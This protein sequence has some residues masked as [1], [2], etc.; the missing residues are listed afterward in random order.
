LPKSRAK[1]ALNVSIRAIFDKD[2]S[3]INTGIIIGKLNIGIS[4][5]LPP[6]CAAIADTKVKQNEKPTAPKKAITTN[7]LIF[8]MGLPNNILNIIKPK[9]AIIISRPQL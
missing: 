5:A 2:R 4:A 1:L 3:K 6:V 9:P 7:K 8:S